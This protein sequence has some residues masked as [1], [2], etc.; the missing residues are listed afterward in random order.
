M[1]DESQIV[2]LLTEIRDNQT[3][4]I[5]AQKAYQDWAHATTTTHQRRAA[6]AAIVIGIGVALVIWASR[7]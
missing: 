7:M 5:E 1:D 6:I 4:Q 2:R 3:K